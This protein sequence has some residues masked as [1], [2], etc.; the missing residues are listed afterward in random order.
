MTKYSGLKN[1]FFAKNKK[2][3]EKRLKELCGREH[4]RLY[5]NKKVKLN[6]KQVEHIAGWKTYKIVKK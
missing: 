4:S 2:S 1:T 6:R 3:A 5:C